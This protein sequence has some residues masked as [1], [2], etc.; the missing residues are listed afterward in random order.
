MQ[1]CGYERIPGTVV[2]LRGIYT[3]GNGERCTM[4]KIGG[5][6]VV[7]IM[8]LLVVSIIIYYYMNTFIT[9]HQCTSNLLFA[10]FFYTVSQKTSPMFIAYSLK[11][12]RIFVIFG[13]NITEKV[14][15]QK[16]LYFPT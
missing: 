11:H 15:N 12:C 4:A 13:R 3:R 6:N 2:S 9:L 5:G 7:M 14:G 16:M 8:M 1:V 10:L